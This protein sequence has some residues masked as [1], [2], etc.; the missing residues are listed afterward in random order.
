MFLADCLLPEQG[1]VRL[2]LFPW[3]WYPSRPS[4]A[5]MLFLTYTALL[6]TFTVSHFSYLQ[7]LYPE[8]NFTISSLSS[9]FCFSFQSK[10]SKYDTEICHLLY[11]SLTH[12]NAH[13]QKQRTIDNSKH[14]LILLIILYSPI[15][16]QQKALSLWFICL[17]RFSL[18]HVSERATSQHISSIIHGAS[19]RANE[20]CSF[21]FT[22]REECKVGHF[23]H[24]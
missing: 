16:G 8:L 10:G 24:K 23:S 17:M 3:Y 18:L 5:H 21:S 20:T 15:C 13:I 9:L 12:G 11:A 14:P 6:V 22:E 1:M 4:S 2:W 19:Q 7:V